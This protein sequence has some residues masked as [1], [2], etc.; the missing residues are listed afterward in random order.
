MSKRGKCDFER[1]RMRLREGKEDNQK[2]AVAGRDEMKKYRHHVHTKETQP[3]LRKAVSGLQSTKKP[4]GNDELKHN[5]D[6][7]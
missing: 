1:D 4:R 3:P 7:F 2:A 6:N 5:D